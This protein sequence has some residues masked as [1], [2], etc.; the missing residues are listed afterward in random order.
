[1]FVKFY[2]PSKDNK[3]RILDEKKA[4]AEFNS[5]VT[6][7]CE[8]FGGATVTEGHGYFLSAEKSIIAEPV[9][10]IA[11][12]TDTVTDTIKADISALASTVKAALCQESIMVEFAEKSEFI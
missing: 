3:G 12:Y 6:K 5:V 7:F 2:F 9:R 4:N 1:M 10:I 11:S 8:N